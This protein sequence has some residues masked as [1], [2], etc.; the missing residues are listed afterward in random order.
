MVIS[1]F[2]LEIISWVI[3]LVIKECRYIQVL[4]EVGF[5]GFFIVFFNIENVLDYEFF[6][7]GKVVYCIIGMVLQEFG[8]MD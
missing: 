2:L 1:F 8:I 5:V 7:I 3:K 4:S 6:F